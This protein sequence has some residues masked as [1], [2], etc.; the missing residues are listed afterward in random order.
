MAG[1]R[2]LPPLLLLPPPPL[3]LL[4]AGAQLQTQ[5][6]DTAAGGNLVLG[7][8]TAAEQARSN[9]CPAVSDH[10]IVAFCDSALARINSNSAANSSTGVE[11]EEEPK[12]VWLSDFPDGKPPLLQAHVYCMIFAAPMCFATAMIVAFGRFTSW[13][14]QLHITMALSTWVVTWIGI[15]CIVLHIEQEGSGHFR[16]SHH[17]IGM[18]IGIVLTLH[19]LI[20]AVRPKEP[21]G[22]RSVYGKVDPDQLSG[23]RKTWHISHAVTAFSVLAAGYGYQTLYSGHVTLHGAWAFPLNFI[24]FIPVAILKALLEGG[25]AQLREQVEEQELRKLAG[26]GVG[27]GN[28]L[29]DMGSPA[30]LELVT[31]PDI[32]ANLQRFYANVETGALSPLILFGLVNCAIFIPHNMMGVFSLPSVREAYDAGDPLM[33]AGVLGIALFAS[34]GVP[35]WLLEARRTVNPVVDGGPGYLRQLGVGRLMLT[36]RQARAI[37]KCDTLHMLNP[38]AAPPNLLPPVVM[39]I[40]VLYYGEGSRSEPYMNRISASVLGIFFLFVRPLVSTFIV[41]LQVASKLAAFQVEAVAKA[42][43]NFPATPPSEADDAREV[44]GA[45]R[46]QAAAAAAEPGGKGEPDWAKWE[47]E[48]VVPLRQLVDTMQILTDGWGRGMAAV[49]FSSVFMVLGQTCVLLSPMTD[50]LVHFGPD[51]P[52]YTRMIN[53][54]FLFLFTMI[55]FSLAGGPAKVSTACDD[56][57]ETL[58][59]I[60]LANPL[61]VEVDQRVSIL[62][63][64][65]TNVNRGQGI[66]FK[67]FDFVIDQKVLTKIFL[68]IVSAISFLAPIML[69]LSRGEQVTP[70]A[71]G[72]DKPPG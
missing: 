20:A 19:I 36:P 2:R 17:I 72:D 28:P 29:S 49:A 40:L 53:C 55:P 21:A 13:W 11:A 6:H 30:E 25:E 26:D 66:G 68:Q 67:V 41:T 54:F 5:A 27:A 58:N 32:T 61:S 57:K 1:R 70:G 39:S 14:L 22:S 60:R 52:L 44:P 23:A 7:G 3:L 38:K 35:F 10:E 34:V 50:T 37:K 8:A 69:G 51:T 59:A 4:L 43:Q 12:A 45:E 65:L 47:E 64:C 33:T 42:V 46:P 9:Q 24:L 62:E 56:L 16:T 31:C 71:A 18:A 15:G 48:V 63:R